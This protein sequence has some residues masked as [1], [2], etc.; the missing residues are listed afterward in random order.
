MYLN[1]GSYRGWFHDQSYLI[2]KSSKLKKLNT[3][4]KFNDE[5]FHLNINN[6][7]SSYKMYSSEKNKYYNERTSY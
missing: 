3:F 2:S 1:E 7:L 5:P 4:A 6:T